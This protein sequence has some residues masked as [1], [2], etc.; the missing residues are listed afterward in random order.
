MGNDDG[1]GDGGNAQRALMTVLRWRT[2]IVNYV[3]TQ[4]RWAC[5]WERCP[6]PN[7][8]WLAAFPGLGGLEARR[9]MNGIGTWGPVSWGCL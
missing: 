5:P 4:Q 8:V 9:L 1:D 6:S 7:L 2:C 3:R